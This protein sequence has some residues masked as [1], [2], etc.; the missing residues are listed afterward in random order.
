MRNVVIVMLCCLFATAGSA[1]QSI[2]K[3]KTAKPLTVFTVNKKPV[4]TDEFIYLYNKN[5]QNNP[6]DYSNE[7]IEEYL[8][9]FINFK[10]KVEEAE[11]RGYDT[12]AAFKREYN[13]YKDELRKPYLPDSKLTDSLVRLT[14]NRMKEEVRAS[15]ILVNVKPDANPDDT[16]KAYNKIINIRNKALAGDD[17]GSLAATYSEDPSAKLNKGDLGYFTALQMVYPFETAAYTT[18][19][20]QISMPIR[21]KFGYHIVKVADRRPTRGEVEVSHIMIRTGD[22]KDNQKAKNTIFEVYDELNAG[23]SW[24]E[25]CKQYSEDPGTKDNGGRMRAFGAG[26]MNSVPAFEE[27][28]FSLQKPGDISDPFQT[29][30]GWHIVRLEKKIPLATYEELSSSLR[31]KVL[32][33]ERA[34]ISKQAMQKKLR[35]D[36]QFHENAAVKSVVMSWADSTLVK[37]KWHA[38]SDAKTDKEVLFTL[39]DKSYTVKDF[40]AYVYKSQHANTTFPARYLD[41]LYNAYVD[42]DI[43]QLFE[44]NLT[45][46]NPEYRML[47]KEYYEGILL[48]EIMEREVWTKASDDS[49]GQRK[50][51]EANTS[52]YAA[53]ERIKGIL[54][55][56]SSNDVLQT[57]HALV[58]QGDSVKIQEYITAQKIRHE[59]GSFEKDSKPML[60][61]IDWTPG[62]HEV[63]SGNTYYLVWIKNIL[64]PGIKSFEEARAAVISDYQNYLEKTWLDVLKKKYP[65][66]INDKGKNYV[67]SHL[68]K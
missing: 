29:Q 43:L 58:K 46:N 47:L 48:F 68:Q 63:E 66:K 37:G 8:T 9:L 15:H 19:V 67:L 59:T 5:H 33:D 3:T 4:T 25:L 61:K 23:V 28:A 18:P 22:N 42:S 2:K 56:A 12:T 24:D 6:G 16:L 34:Q 21:T 54:Y 26:F 14:Y 51:Y 41:Q 53:G 50:Y 10:L 44:Q 7:K 60:S 49:V 52:K 1:Q 45:E 31:N 40:M 20:G 55:S 13:S 17:F 27:A 30:Y 57:L 36:Y 38:K 64:P 11:H 39:R 35:K 32:R 65:V 62:A